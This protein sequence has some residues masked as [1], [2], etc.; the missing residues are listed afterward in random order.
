M[1]IVEIDIVGT[2]ET[3][4][5]NMAETGAT[6]VAGEVVVG[7]FV[8]ATTL[9][10]SKVSAIRGIDMQNKGRTHQRVTQ[11]YMYKEEKKR[12]GNNKRKKKKKKGGGNLTR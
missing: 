10:S 2:A 1:G 11:I 5:E 9:G 12:K 3:G 8:F 6:S 7:I 4:A